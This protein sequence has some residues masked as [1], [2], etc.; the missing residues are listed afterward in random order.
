ML[1]GLHVHL[2]VGEEHGPGQTIVGL[3]GVVLLVFCLTGLVLWW[4]GLRRLP[5]GFRIYWKRGATRLNFD[6]HRVLGIVLVIPLFALVLTGVYLVFPGY[7]RPIYTSFIDA[8]RPPAAP[9]SKPAAGAMPISLEA[10]MAQAHQAVPGTRVTSVHIPGR[11]NGL[12]RSLSI[13]SIRL[14]FRAGAARS[15]SQR[16]RAQASRADAA[17]RGRFR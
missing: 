7:V 4:P 15:R 1:I 16:L 12:M 11:Q 9:L 5:S 13:I 6:L 17:A 10:A 3:G 8:P 2:L 14:F